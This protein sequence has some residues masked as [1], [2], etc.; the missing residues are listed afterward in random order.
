MKN[1]LS[2]FVIALTI[3][4]SVPSQAQVEFGLKAGANVSKLS[5]SKDVFNVENR[6]GF[7]V[8]PMIEFTVPIVGLALMQPCFMTKKVQRLRVKQKRLIMLIFLLI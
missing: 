8:G 5:F 4:V 1:Y 3:L 2:I 7:F 6:S